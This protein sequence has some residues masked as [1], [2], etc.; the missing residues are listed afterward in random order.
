MIF[1]NGVL[2][3]HPQ[4]DALAVSGDRILALGTS[5]EVKPLVGDD[6]D[7]IDLGGRFLMPGFI[8]AHVHLFHVGL[9]ESGWR[10]DLAGAERDEALE[11]LRVAVETRGRG[12]WV[13]GGGWDESRWRIREYL[14][15]ADLDRIAPDSPVLAVRMDG[16]ILVANSQAFR[17]MDEHPFDGLDPSLVD[18]ANGL[19]REESGWALLKRIEPDETALR[20]AVIAAAA[21]CHRHGVTSVHTMTHSR[22]L[23]PLQERI[24]AARLRTTVYIPVDSPFDV[25]RVGP[26]DGQTGPWLRIGGA[27]IFADGSIGAQNAALSQ[28]YVSGGTGKL[29][30]GDE[31]LRV[32]IERAERSGHPTAIHAIGDRAIEQVLSIH[33]GVGTSTALRHRIEHFELPGAGHLERARDAG[34]TVCMQPNFIGNWSGPDSMYVDRFG[35]ERDSASNPLR[36]VVDSGLPLA[37]GSDGMPVG[38]LYGLHWAVNAPYPGQQLSVGEALVCYTEA[39]A[40]LSFEEEVKGKLESGMLADLVVLDEDPSLQPGSID[41]RVVE[42]TVVGGECVYR[43]EDST[44]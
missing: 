31:D 3:G 37:F 5:D 7:I 41:Q 17:W 12:E 22:R 38:P 11:R 8:D 16:H 6:T 30:W 19:L 43:R 20:E 27:K 35:S 44:S 23:P 14:S 36:Q 42:L 9:I 34:I 40:R 39:P 21:H 29:N 33:E 15:R 25:G 28:P 18:E 2:H 1:V 13:I 26:G 24:E 10:I 4:A 32:L